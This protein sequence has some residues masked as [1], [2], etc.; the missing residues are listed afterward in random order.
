MRYQSGLRIDACCGAVRLIIHC[1]KKLSERLPAVSDASLT[2]TSPL[3]SWHAHRYT[4]D[5]RQ[6]VLFCHDKTRYV[7]FVAGLRKPQFAQLGQLHRELFQ[8]CLAAEGMSERLIKAAT[9]LLG[10]PRFD[11]A[12]HASVLSSLRVAKQDLEAWVYRVPNVLDLDPIE[13]SVWLNERPVTIN[14][15]WGHPDRDMA[16]LIKDCANPAG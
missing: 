7:L 10:E 1:T 9:L 3:G 2:E 16:R 11:R 6:C 8:A 12:T 14:K 4:I 13:V 5:R 15:V